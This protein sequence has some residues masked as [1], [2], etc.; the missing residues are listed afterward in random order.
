MSKLEWHAPEFEYRE[1]SVSWQ[2]LTILF[3]ILV[4]ALSI[5][6][7][8]FL[9]GFFVVI[10]EILILVWGN[11]KP[12]DIHFELTDR[13]LTIDGKK[14]YLFTELAGFSVDEE[15]K[16][17][18]EFVRAVLFFKRRLRPTLRILIPLAHLTELKQTMNAVIPELEHRDTLTDTFQ[19]LIGF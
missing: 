13:S 16:E 11:E 4:L 17:K 3:A 15:A 19:D 9:F 12:R 8:N 1:K 14:E 6:Q 18:K 2:W 7:K 10:A 5:W